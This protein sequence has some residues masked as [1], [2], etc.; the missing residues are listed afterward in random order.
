MQMMIPLSH[1]EKMAIG[2]KMLPESVIE[3]FP[4]NDAGLVLRDFDDLRQLSELLVLPMSEVLAL[5]S[6]DLDDGV[7]VCRKDEG[8]VRTAERGGKAYYTY[9]HLATS[10]DAPE[11][12]ALRVSVHCQNEEDV[13]LN[14]GHGSKEIVYV[15][16]GRIRMHW[17]AGDVRRST[18]LDCGDTAY[19]RPN[20]P[21]SFISLEGESELLAFNY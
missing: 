17:Q 13:V 4:V 14:A 1:V 2:R 12:M 5:A 21:H 15:T 7:K 16:K 19:V 9:Q 11:L 18:D 20:V 8:F 3:K 6:A 10:A